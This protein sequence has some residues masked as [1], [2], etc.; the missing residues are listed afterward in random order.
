[1][2]TLEEAKVKKLEEREQ[3]DKHPQDRDNKGDIL[4]GNLFFSLGYC[5]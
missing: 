2:Q 3:M 4:T 5:S 1:M